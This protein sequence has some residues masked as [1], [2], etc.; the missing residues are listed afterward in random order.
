MGAWGA[1][2]GSSYAPVVILNSAGVACSIDTSPALELRDAN[3][4]L[5]MTGEGAPNAGSPLRIATGS[6][7]ISYLGFSN[8]CIAPPTLPFEFDL[9][10]GDGRARITPTAASSAIGL[11]HCNSA[12]E[13]PPPSLFWS[14]PFGLPGG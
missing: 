14:G 4:S 10:I 8:W 9:V 6:T 12:P 5:L 2:A 7:A 13:T 3:G 1:A 11:P